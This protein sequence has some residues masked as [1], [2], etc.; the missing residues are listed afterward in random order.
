MLVQKFFQK[1]SLVLG[2]PAGPAAARAKS[3]SSTPNRT[4][5]NTKNAIIN[6]A[7][8]VSCGMCVSWGDCR[9]LSCRPVWQLPTL[10][11]FFFPVDSWGLAS[12][13][14]RGLVLVPPVPLSILRTSYP[15]TRGLAQ[16]LSAPVCVEPLG[17]NDPARRW[18][19]GPLRNVNRQS[20][21]GKILEQIVP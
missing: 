6:T 12:I 7:N 8:A 5:G 10:P 18:W 20:V 4:V 9:V 13:V 17:S 16:R 11:V 1:F 19:I 3:D 2:G 15:R 21:M 14:H